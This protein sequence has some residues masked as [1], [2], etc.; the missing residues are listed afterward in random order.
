MPVG[1]VIANIPG[2]Q[3]LQGCG[4]DCAY[5]GGIHV[6]RAI[7]VDFFGTLLPV[8]PQFIRFLSRAAHYAAGFVQQH[9]RRGAYVDMGNHTCHPAV[10]L[11]LHGR[12]RVDVQ[13]GAFGLPAENYAIQ[14]GT[15]PAT[16][17]ASRFPTG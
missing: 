1:N 15:H 13:L 7:A 8:P 14:T 16:T 4:S 11:W 6:H 12:L 17:T 9:N 5:V 2:G 3:R 10:G